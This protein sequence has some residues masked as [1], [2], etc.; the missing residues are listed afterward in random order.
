MKESKKRNKR[1]ELKG[2]EESA[3]CIYFI[4]LRTAH[5]LTTALVMSFPYSSQA[6][7][8]SLPLSVFIFTVF[9][10]LSFL[11]PFISFNLTL[12]FLHLFIFSLFPYFYYHF[13]PF[14]PCLASIPPSPFRCP[15]SVIRVLSY[16]SFI[17]LLF[18]SLPLFS[19]S[20]PIHLLPFSLPCSS[21]PHLQ[22][23]LYF[24]SL[25]LQS[26]FI[27]TSLLLPSF[28]LSRPL[29]HSPFFPS[30]SQFSFPPFIFPPPYPRFLLSPSTFSSS[31]LSLFFLMFFFWGVSYAI[32]HSSL[33]LLCFSSSS[34]HSSYEPISP[35]PLFCLFSYLESHPSIPLTSNPRLRSFSFPLLIFSLFLFSRVHSFSP[36][37]LL[38]SSA[39]YCI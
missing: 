22:L 21:S 8:S 27:S 17:I 37:F 19:Y 20:Y 14:F 5:P 36:P 33:L 25:K 30:P 32:L 11:F 4:S 29:F 28:S 23:T 16:H 39:F 10:V 13:L 34:L 2:E 12:Q 18:T 38:S 31:R 3:L 35:I 24:S 9:S 6:V 1:R 7:H 26:P 15:C